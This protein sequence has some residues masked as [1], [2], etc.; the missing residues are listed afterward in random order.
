MRG[1]VSQLVKPYV[2]GFLNWKKQQI[3]NALNKGATYGGT[4]PK[5]NKKTIKINS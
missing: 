2:V 3:P 1:D 4:P 5:K